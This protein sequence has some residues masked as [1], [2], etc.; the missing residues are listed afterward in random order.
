MN[1][2]RKEQKDKMVC[3]EH[4]GV[5]F[6]TFEKLLQIPC[7]K[8]GFSTRMGG[9]SEGIYTSM[10]LSYTRG[11]EE[12]AVTKNFR[13]MMAALEMDSS[14]LVFSDQTHTTNIRVVTAR[15]R[16]KG[17]TK[18]RDYS[19]IDGLVTN[20]P[21]LVLATFYADCVPLYF[22]D[23]VKKAIGLSHSGWRG[24]VGKI[25]LKTVELMQAEYGCNPADMIGCIAPSICQDC[26]EVSEDVIVEFEK[27]F[28]EDAAL[29]YY[30]KENGKYQLN[31]WKANELVMKEA[32]LTQEHIVVTD[33]CT[34]CNADKLFSHRASH[35]QRG[36]LGAFLMLKEE[37]EIEK[38]NTD[39]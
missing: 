34:C 8:H 22:V 17:F 36:N 4:A 23:P 39:C 32:G 2:I 9:V 37:N 33:I 31:L 38:A 12:N 10:N 14:N 24:T 26:Y 21:G 16:G 7:I 6:L 35:G 28:G 18:K 19:D 5:P 20:V 1:W 3:K 11:D 25:G 30:K 27:A 15:D 13:R 29:L